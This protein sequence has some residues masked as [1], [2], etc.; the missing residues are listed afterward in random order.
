MTL[1]ACPR[2]R[3]WRRIGSQREWREL[4]GQPIPALRDLLAQCYE[5]VAEAEQTGAVLPWVE[6]LKRLGHLNA[7][8]RPWRHL[9]AARQPAQSAGY[10][11]AQ[12]SVS[13]VR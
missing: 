12:R 13:E 6:E 7:R 2:I 3:S 9:W 8:D 4:R 5:T 1:P 11:L 10:A